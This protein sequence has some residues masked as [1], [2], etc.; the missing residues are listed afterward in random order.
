M[1]F[2]TLQ[3]FLFID[4]D[5][6]VVLG[7]KVVPLSFIHHTNIGTSRLLNMKLVANLLR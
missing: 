7:K 3:R 1:S 4:L 6:Q 2:R 5:E